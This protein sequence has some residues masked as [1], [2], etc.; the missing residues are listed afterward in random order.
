M[1]SAAVAGT[2]RLALLEELLSFEQPTRPNV[3]M[4]ERV[5]G[6]M[7][8]KRV[9]G[10]RAASS[11]FVWSL[12]WQNDSRHVGDAQVATKIQENRILLNG[13]GRNGLAIPSLPRPT[14]TK[15]EFGPVNNLGVGSGDRNDSV[16]AS[17]DQVE[18]ERGNE[19]QAPMLSVV[20]RRDNEGRV[21]GV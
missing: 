9:V 21:K 20:N 7:F 18:V 8:T 15:T 6:R 14:R 10:A 16:G 11:G 19:G 5:M 13:G 4:S 17:V 2:R 1:I 3:A 12:G